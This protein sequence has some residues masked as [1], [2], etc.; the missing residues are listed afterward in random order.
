MKF[1]QNLLLASMA[2]LS[3]ASINSYAG[4]QGVNFYYGLGL[5]AILPANYDITAAGNLLGHLKPLVMPASKPAQMIL[6]LITRYQAHNMAWLIAQLK[7]TT[8]GLNL[9]LVVRI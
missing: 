5:G 9:K 3:L 1:K 4:R 2:L 7:E 6:L 8:S